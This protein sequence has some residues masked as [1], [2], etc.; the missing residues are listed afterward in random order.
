MFTVVLASLFAA[1]LGSLL[2]TM[3]FVT[4]EKKGVTFRLT[5]AVAW[6]LVAILL[7]GKAFYKFGEDHATLI[8]SGM[9]IPVAHRPDL[10]GKTIRPISVIQDGGAFLIVGSNRRLYSLLGVQLESDLN[11][12]EMIDRD[13]IIYMKGSTV[14]IGVKEFNPLNVPTQIGYSTNK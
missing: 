3:T 1:L 9:S 2:S 12:T 11:L 13:L 5:F 8:E 14:C 4:F 6:T 7:S 10:V